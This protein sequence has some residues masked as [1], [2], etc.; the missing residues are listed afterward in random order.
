MKADVLV[1]EIGST[2]TVVTAFGG[3]NSDPFIIGQGEFYT[4][5]KQGDVN[6]GIENAVKNLEKNINSEI[7]WDMLL[8]SSSAA[9]GLKMTVHGLVYDMTVKASKEAALGAGAVLKYATAG[10]LRNSQIDKIYEIKP[11]VILLSGGVDYGE[12]EIILYNAEML[13]D[14]ELDIPFIYAGNIS[15][16]D[17][18]KKIFSEKNKNIIITDNVYPSVD[19]LNIIPARKTIQ[20]VF[21]GHIIHAPGMEK[22]YSL[23]DRK[24]IPTPG[25]VMLTTEMLSEIYNDVLT[26]DI[27]GATTDVDSVTFGDPEIQRILIS[28]EPVSKRTVEGDMG[29]YVN[30]SHV[31]ELIGEEKVSEEF[32]DYKELIKNISPYPENS[33]QEEFSVY[34]AKYCFLNGIKR[35]AGMKKHLYGPNGRQEIA[36]GKDL[37]AIKY[38]FGTGGILSRSEYRKEIMEEIKKEKD[39]NALIP[40][41]KIEIGYDCNYIFAPIG[42]LSTVNYEAAMKLLRKDIKII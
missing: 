7:S 30:A 29:L 19:T 33:R 32:P 4:T 21:S 12:E 31:I 26:V 18:I 24:I 17:E 2:T 14:I 27:G 5:I 42:V 10:K 22:I 11:N 36:Q 34:L 16:K 1:A 3:I 13:S 35:H 23:V 25:A 41:K 38:I 6:I 9:G 39:L 15:I 28:P 8:A 20:D 40:G 37:T